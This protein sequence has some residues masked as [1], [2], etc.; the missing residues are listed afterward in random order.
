MDEFRRVRL[1]STMLRS[2]DAPLLQRISPIMILLMCLVMPKNTHGLPL[3]FQNPGSVAALPLSSL[4]NHCARVANQKELCPHHNHRSPSLVLL[5]AVD[6]SSEAAAAAS[7]QELQKENI[8]DERPVIV[9]FPSY[10]ALANMQQGDFVTSSPFSVIDGGNQHQKH[11]F[12][13]VLYPRGGGHPSSNTNNNIN[14]SNKERDEEE[15]GFGMSYKI[16]PIF[17]PGSLKNSNLGVYLQYINNDDD[18]STV[19]ATF[20]LRLKGKQNAGPRFDVEFS[21][22]MRFVPEGQ[23]KLSDGLAN[24]YGSHLMQAELLP[25]FLGVGASTTTIAQQQGGNGS[26]GNNNEKYDEQLDVEVQIKVHT[27]S[28]SCLKDTSS[29]NNNIFAFNDIRNVK[30]EDG[31]KGEDVHDTEQVRVGKI[32]VP[33]VSSLEQRSRMFQQGVYPGV[34]YRITRILDGKEPGKDNTMTSTAKEAITSSGKEDA[35]FERDLFLSQPGAEYEMKPIYPL[36]A[37]LEREWPVR[38]KESD[39][40]KLFTPNM[41]NAASAIGSLFT[42]VGGLTVAFL[43]SQLVSLYFIPSKSMDPTL[44]VGDVLL[45]EKVTPRFKNSN[46]GDVVLFTPPSPLVDIVAASSNGGKKLSD[47]D[48]FVKRIAAGPGDAV[49]TTKAGSVAINGQKPVGRRDLCDTEPLR[50]I[51]KYITPVD[52]ENNIVPENSV[53]VMGD[54]SSVS[55]DSRVWGSLSR[56]NIVGRPIFRLFPLKRFGAVP[57]LPMQME[58]S[59]AVDTTTN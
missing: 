2:I 45:V 43:L 51:E 37:Q 47:R 59:E 42:A 23:G 28:A 29:G 7:S 15:G 18:S 44:Q 21:A 33:V 48:L 49:S 6:D 30:K 4:L 8:R 36:V 35:L 31:N 12:R 16:L 50:L 14:T 46:V 11:E 40:P 55:V 25:S 26:N 3:S 56:D 1:Y 41:Y 53:F 54:C 34:E 38:V 22:G 57:P 19:D 32:V 27:S 52:G 24:D 9:T 13:V 20:R 39:I 58:E 5:R 17:Q 10:W